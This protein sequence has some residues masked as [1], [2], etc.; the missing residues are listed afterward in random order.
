[1][2]KKPPKS[3]QV[4]S[5]GTGTFFEATSTSYREFPIPSVEI[6]NLI[7]LCYKLKPAPS[8]YSKDD[9]P[10]LMKS[11]I[12]GRFALKLAKAEKEYFLELTKDFDLINYSLDQNDLIELKACL[13]RISTN[14]T[15]STSAGSVPTDQK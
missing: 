12:S 8:L 3:T 14:S 4:Q 11:S 6:D 7:A 2:E 15:R 10:T 13:R 5:S 1:M 9:P